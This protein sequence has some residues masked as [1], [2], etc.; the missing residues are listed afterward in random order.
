MGHRIKSFLTLFVVATLAALSVRLVLLEDFR[1]AS[2]SMVPS[3]WP[4]DLVFVSKL[5]FNVRLPFSAYELVNLRRPR[6]SE[7]VAFSLPDRGIDTFVKRV[8]AAEGDKVAITD[9]HLIVNG[10]PATY[11]EVR[12][13][14]VHDG[15]LNPDR[16]RWEDVGEGKPYLIQWEEKSKMADYG[17]VDVPPGHFF[18]L[19]DNRAES[20]DSRNWGPVPYSCLKGKVALVWLSVDLLGHIRKS[21]IGLSVR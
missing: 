14:E 18:V 12:A 10:K 17:P 3:L 8:V 11:R 15:V 9:G 13:D 1:I 2:N 4:G 21:R 5:S 7:I 19:G 16:A 20:T 6:N